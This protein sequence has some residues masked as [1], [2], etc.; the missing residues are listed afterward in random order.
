ML[1]TKYL[2]P[3][4]DPTRFLHI[5]ILIFTFDTLQN[6]IID[7]HLGNLEYHFIIVL[8]LFILLF[9]LLIPILTSFFLCEFGNWFLI[10]LRHFEY[11]K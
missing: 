10:A 2:H 7:L 8:V 3:R 5:V 11:F 1:K 6:V 9:C 4:N